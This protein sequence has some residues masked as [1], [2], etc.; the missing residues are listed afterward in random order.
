MTLVDTSVWID[1]FR[2]RKISSGLKQLILDN[3]VA[4]H[5]WVLGELLLG[6]LGVQRK[7]IISDLTLFPM[8][9]PHPIEELYNFIEKGRLYA[10]GISFTD[11]ELL[12]TAVA[13][14]CLLWTLDRSLHRCA[15]TYRKAYLYEPAP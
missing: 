11:V 10:K 2:G 6:H 15:A 13:E 9:Q 3:Q 12:Y 7:D 5:Q 1:Y 8:F 14:D 4:C